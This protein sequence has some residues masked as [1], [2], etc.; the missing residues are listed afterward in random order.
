LVR[1]K[2][3]GKYKV[4]AQVSAT[5]LEYVTIHRFCTAKE[6]IR[7]LNLSIKSE[8]T[9]GSILKNL[10]IG[11]FIAVRKPFINT[12]NQEKRYLLLNYNLK[13]KNSIVI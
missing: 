8:T 7:D 12:S 2:R 5:V 9:I 13:I 10:G 1:K 4:T 11:S 6:I 3:C